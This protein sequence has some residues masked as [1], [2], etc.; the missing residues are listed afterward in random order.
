LRSLELAEADS[1]AVCSGA[2][3]LPA[4]AGTRAGAVLLPESL[5]DSAG[6][7][8]RIIVADPAQ[9]IATAARLLHPSRVTTS[10]IDPSARIGTGTTLGATPRVGA[11]VLIGA[12][13]R[14]GDRVRIGPHVVIEDG[15]VLGDDVRIDAG[16]VIHAHAV[17]GDRVWCQARSVIAG[18][19]F[20]FHSDASGHRRT[21]QVGGC[22]LADDVEIGAGCCIDRGSLDDTVIGRGTKLDNLVH[23]G[24]NARI[25]E[26]CLVMAGV[27]IAGSVVVGNRVILAGQSGVAGHLSIGDDAR[28]GAQAGVISYVAAGTSV[29]GYPARPHRDFLR[30]MAALYRLTPIVDAL[31]ALVVAEEQDDG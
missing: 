23:I 7:A 18:E 15:V 8:T 24:H 28:I 31:E 27:G 26:H 30:A 16:V 9:A 12:G 14:I 5:V 22:I 29:S 25:G 10:Q 20:G 3:Y 19:G 17:L 6:P 11:F 4:M 13:V 1:L 21:P 2:K